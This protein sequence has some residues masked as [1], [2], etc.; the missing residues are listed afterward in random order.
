MFCLF[1]AADWNAAFL[2]TV[3]LILGDDV[4]GLH[5]SLQTENLTLQA[6]I[7]CI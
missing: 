7:M 5:G 6:L 1:Q 3:A 4:K 2:F